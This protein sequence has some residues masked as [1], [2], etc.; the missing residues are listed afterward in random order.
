MSETSTCAYPCRSPT[1]RGASRLAGE[2]TDETTGEMIV[3]TTGTTE[4]EDDETTTEISG[5]EVGETAGETET[6][7]AK[8]GR[9]LRVNDP[10]AL[11]ARSAGP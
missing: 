7:A 6:E 3:E 9:A 10:S 5:I 2:K 1:T 4:T 11:T 8:T